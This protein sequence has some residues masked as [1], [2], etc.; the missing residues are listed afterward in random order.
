MKQNEETLEMSQE[1]LKYMRT[2]RKGGDIR[3]IGKRNYTFNV[4]SFK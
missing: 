1:K 4:D 3:K 2:D